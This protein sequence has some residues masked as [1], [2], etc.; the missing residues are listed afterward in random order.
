MSKRRGHLRRAFTLAE[1]TVAS[2]IIVLVLGSVSASVA[3]LGRAKN[4]CKRRF[5]AHLRADVA[6]NALRRDIISI[7]RSDDLFDTQLLLYSDMIPTPAGDMECLIPTCDDDALLD[8]LVGQ[9]VF[10]KD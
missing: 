1:V 5:D 10:N 8:F 9:N 4:S 6:L 2:I 7:V 3:Q